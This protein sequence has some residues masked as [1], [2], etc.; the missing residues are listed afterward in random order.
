MAVL[1]VSVGLVVLLLYSFSLVWKCVGRRRLRNCYL[2]DYVCFK[3]AD[4]RKISTDFAGQIIARNPRLG[5]PEYK[6][7]LKVIVNSGIGEETYGPR[8]ILEGREESPTHADAM[9][10]MDDCLFPTLDAL[11]RKTGFRPADIDV[12]AVNVSMFSPAPSLASRLVNRF[13]MR[14]DVRVFN[15]SGMGC[16]ASLV[17]VDL[18][19]NVFRAST[20]GKPVLA[21]VVTSESISPNWYSGSDKSMM[22]GNCL[23]RSGGCAL[24]LTNDPALRGRAKLRLRRL[25]RTHIG[26]GDEAYGCAVQREDDA[27]LVGFH[28]SKDLP[29]AAVRAFVENLRVLAPQILPVRELLRYAV[30]LARQKLAAAAAAPPRKGE[31][32]RIDF[33]SGVEHFCL[34][35]GG[36]AVIEAVGRSL[37]LSKFDLEPARMTLHRWGNTSASSLW[38]VLG[39]ME[40]KR[41]LKRR[42]RV[43]MISFGAGFKCNSALWEVQADLSGDA[44][45][46]ADCVHHYPPQT[47]V[48][49]FMEKYGWVNDE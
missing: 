4:D 33:R 16:S 34:H 31:A 19:N 35:T 28:L 22:L 27:G 2:L 20:T 43:L 46:W 25:V 18:V 10:E 49:P 3:P 13:N 39:Y 47:L 40:A 5:F 41:R 23:F 1:V 6:F 37:G 30:R 24:L 48:N 14:E 17:A 36:A 26:A 32:A 8:N 45:V 21:A 42:D 29:K 15:L 12:L 9:Q 38:Y 7:L 11:F 44:A